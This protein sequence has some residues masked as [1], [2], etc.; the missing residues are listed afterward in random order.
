MFGVRVFFCLRDA[1]TGGAAGPIEVLG[2][3]DSCGGAATDS[4]CLFG[5]GL[6]LFRGTA[7]ESG[8]KRESGERENERGVLKSLVFLYGEERRE[9]RGGGGI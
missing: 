6:A 3:R 9:G 5:E 1:P 7:T 4:A 8:G 2:S